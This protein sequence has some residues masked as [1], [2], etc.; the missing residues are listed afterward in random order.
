[1]DKFHIWMSSL[2]NWFS[3]L[4]QITFICKIWKKNV[5]FKCF[6]FMNGFEYVFQ[7]CYSCKFWWTNFTFECLPFINWFNMLFQITFICKI[8]RTNVTF[9]CFSLVWSGVCIYLQIWNFLNL[10]FSVN[11][12][13][14]IS[15]L[16]VF[17]SWTDSTYLFK[18]LL[19][20]N[21]EWKM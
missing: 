18:L 19:S 20:V 2:M 14:Q 11:F 13:G 1:M 8:W 15:H 3:I 16:N 5:T 21:F 9:E 17:P 6:S 12:D 4:I 10:P 7:V